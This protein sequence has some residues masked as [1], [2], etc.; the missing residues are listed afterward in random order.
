LDVINVGLQIAFAAVFVV[1]LQRYLRDRRPVNRDLTLVAGAVAGW[2][3]VSTAISLFPALPAEL[4][5]LSPVFIL[6]Q[7]Y[8]TLRLVGH[9]VP[10]ERNLRLAAVAW[11]VVAL[12]VT[13]GIGIRGNPVATAVVVSYFVVF[14]A[15]AAIILGRVAQSRV[16][17]AR[18]RF[19]I[20]AVGTLLFAATILIAGIATAAARPGDPLD[21]DV[22]FTSRLVALAAGLSYLAAFM[23]PQPLRRLQERA[24]AFDLGQ[25]LMAVPD[26]DL[27]GP[28]KALAAI[29]ERITGARAVIVSTGRPPVVRATAGTPP[30]DMDPTFAVPIENGDQ[31]GIL[32][33]YL[34]SGSL[35]LEDDRSLLRLLAGQAARSADQQQA[36]LERNVLESEL[37]SASQE[38]EESRAQLESE[39]RFRVALEAHPGILLVVDPDGSIGYANEQA[40]SSLGYDR[41]SIQAVRLS[42]LLTTT[43]VVGD[44]A[45]AVMPAEAR[46]RDGTVFPVDYAVSTFESG[47]DAYSMAVL[48][49]ISDRLQTERLRDTFIGMLSH[50]LRTPVTAIYGGSQVLLSRGDRLDPNTRHEL[51]ADVA[52]ESERLHR[53]I[54][55]LLVLA[56]VE[57]GQD[58]AGGEP[59]LLQRVLPLIVERERALW[60][61][62]RIDMVIPPG[63]AT[64][65][66]HDGHVG[67]VVRNLL[68]NAAKYAGAGASVQIVAE[69][70]ANGVTVRVLDDGAG[71]QSEHADHLFDLYYRAPGAADRAPGAGIGLFVCR[72]IVS[73]LGGSIWARPR[74]D[75]G[76]E[77]GFELPIYEPEDEPAPVDTEESGLAAIS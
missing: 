67:Q 12:A 35:F 63:L 15:G 9:F 50:E 16:G 42:D 29:A 13:L 49:D 46:R 74:P 1:V 69:G 39:A 58:L 59:V 54:E 52:S 20:A 68:S 19:W 18:T 76:S 28:W 57:R 64:V 8:L 71:I 2:F 7:P 75:G 72:H 21:P 40:L 47:G 70:G 22:V 34:E 73:A 30:S 77:F 10:I 66:G 26:G 11:Y 41:E 14:Q 55:N 6:A 4:A 24:I 51:I 61:G 25:E 33:V 53:L 60:P 45:H 48:T 43:P 5:Q 62:T 65:R 23:P 17:Y 44:S 3:L 37:E 36:V 32:L 27:D 38:L 56:R 31:V